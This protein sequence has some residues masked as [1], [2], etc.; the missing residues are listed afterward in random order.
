MER[1]ADKQQLLVIRRARLTAQLI[2]PEEDTVRM[3]DQQWCAVLAQQTR[4]LARQFAIG[5]PFCNF[6]RR[7]LRQRDDVLARAEVQ[8]IGIHLTCGGLSLSGGGS[9]N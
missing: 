1:G 9:K 2:S 6:L 8:A 3:V 4:G 7:E 5:D